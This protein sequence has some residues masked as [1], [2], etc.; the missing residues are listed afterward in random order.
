MLFIVPQILNI[1][2]ISVVSFNKKTD[3]LL[4]LLRQRIGA[5]DSSFRHRALEEGI[6]WTRN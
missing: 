4:D 5:H 6:P 3:F 1:P 2:T